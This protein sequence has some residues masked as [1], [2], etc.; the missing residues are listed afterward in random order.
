[1]ETNAKE[2]TFQLTKL[3]PYR[4]ITRVASV[5]NLEKKCMRAS[6]IGNKLQKK[7]RRR[8]RHKI[9]SLI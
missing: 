4:E 2:I 3:N 6:S 9:N 7:K 5:N 1:L 8:Q